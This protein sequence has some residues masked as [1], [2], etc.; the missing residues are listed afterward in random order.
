M[1]LSTRAKLCHNHYFR[2]ADAVEYWILQECRSNLA[3]PGITVNGRSE[4]I[5]GDNSPLT[6]DWQNK[7]G[8]RKTEKKRAGATE[9]TKRWQ[10]RGSWRELAKQGN[11]CGDCDGNAVVQLGNA[12]EVARS[13]LLPR[14]CANLLLVWHRFEELGL[15]IAGAR[16]SQS[17]KYRF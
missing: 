9:E 6:S 14:P 17:L 13:T 16:W 11:S 4:R 12:N 1:N 5:T 3:R 15:S 10:I 8:Q 7:K 2:T